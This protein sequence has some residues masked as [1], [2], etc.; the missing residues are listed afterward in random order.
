MTAVDVDMVLGVVRVPVWRHLPAEVARRYLRSYQPKGPSHNH[1]HGANLGFHAD[2]YW[3]V[4]GF[5]ALPTGEDV[6]LVGRCE[7]AGLR[8]RRAAKPSVATSGRLA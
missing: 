7:A 6:D 1:I 3:R 8:I 5:R 2:A 4:G